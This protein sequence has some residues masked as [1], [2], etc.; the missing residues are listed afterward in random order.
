M[1]ALLSKATSLQRGQEGPGEGSCHWFLS[2]ALDAVP[3]LGIPLSPCRHVQHGRGSPAGCR[4]I[5]QRHLQRICDVGRGGQA[6]ALQ[7]VLVLLLALPLA[8]LARPHLGACIG[9]LG[10]RC[11]VSTCLSA[12]LEFCASVA[13][14]AGVHLVHEHFHLWCFYVPKIPP[15]TKHQWLLHGGLSP[16]HPHC[17]RYFN[18]PFQAL[19]GSLPSSTNQKNPLK[20]QLERRRGLCSSVR[21]AGTGVGAGGG[22]RSCG[23]CTA[24][25]WPR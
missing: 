18:Q 1:A 11:D 8:A 5:P 4:R 25:P 17:S 21:W 16:L 15:N 7:G 12:K 22:T 3:R 24:L 2:F 9:G 10:L 20:L 23:S 19:V 13:S 6:L 14:M